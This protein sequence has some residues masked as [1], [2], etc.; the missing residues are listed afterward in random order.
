MVSIVWT[1]VSVVT[2][3]GRAQRSIVLLSSHSSSPSGTTSIIEDGNNDPSPVRDVAVKSR[4]AR[5][6]VEIIQGGTTAKP[7][8]TLRVLL[9]AP[10][11]HHNDVIEMDE[12]AVVSVPGF[13]G[14]QYSKLRTPQ[15]KKALGGHERSCSGKDVCM[16]V[17]G[18][19]VADG[20]CGV[21]PGGREYVVDDVIVRGLHSRSL[22]EGH[23][24]IEGSG[25]S[26]RMSRTNS[27]VRSRDWLW[28]TSREL[29]FVV[30]KELFF[31]RG[32]GE[33]REGS[34]SLS[35]NSLA[36][37]H[38]ASLERVGPPEP[39][40]TLPEAGL[41]AVAAFATGGE[42]R[43]DGIGHGNNR[44][45]S[46]PTPWVDTFRKATRTMAPSSG[47]ASCADESSS[48]PV[49]AASFGDVGGI[50]TEARVRANA[51]VNVNDDVRVGVN[52]SGGTTASGTA[53]PGDK[54]GNSATPQRP[55]RSRIVDG[56]GKAR[57]FVRR[58]SSL[59]MENPAGS[60]NNVSGG[61]GVL[62]GS[63]GSGT[64]QRAARPRSAGK[65]E[66]D[67]SRSSSGR[68]RAGDME[69]FISRVKW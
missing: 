46:E 28:S 9:G 47:M 27:Q 56:A 53:K 45:V 63:V 69:K 5:D 58:M 35:V 40:P 42:T 8:S 32:G 29:G 18:C 30:E 25:S 3:L 37:T 26:S 6:T 51:S 31:E 15:K 60:S 48:N 12:T 66:W 67:A 13:R 68:A 59:D 19:V 52:A 50:T 36:T 16:G 11:P 4:K 65:G 22:S 10:A 34:A 49:A 23:P 39:L 38:T 44:P 61:E 54:E 7:N 55:R 41:G 33:G 1:Y 64:G 20:F 14:G 62:W 21:R 2:H 57:G 24:S 17:R 43:N